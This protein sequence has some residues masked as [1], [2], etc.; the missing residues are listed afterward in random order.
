LETG[1]E[2]GENPARKGERE[3]E[4]KGGI[5]APIERV[6]SIGVLGGGGGS[7]GKQSHADGTSVSGESDAETRSQAQIRAPDG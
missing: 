5:L 2:R 3:R 1:T 4:R 6:T 7:S